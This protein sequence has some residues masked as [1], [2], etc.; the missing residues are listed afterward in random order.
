MNKKI[1]IVIVAALLFV[2][3]NA[4]AWGA[5]GHGAI[6][7]IAEKH[8]TPKAKAECRCYLSH[9]LPYYSSWMDRWRGV[10]P[11]HP[12]NDWHGFPVGANGD[13]DWD[14]ANGKAMGQLHRIVNEM[15]NGNYKK[16][17]DSL[18]RQNL[19][20][21][22]HMLPD[23]HCPVHVTFS[24]K[25]YPEY[26]Y[27]IKRNGRPYKTHTFWD[28]STTFTRKGWTYEKY[29]SEVDK[30]TPKQVKK[31][32]KK[33]NLTYWGQDII[34]QAHRAY[35]LTPKGVDVAE[36]TDEEKAQALALADEMALKAAYRL[37][38]LLNDIFK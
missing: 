32:V 22:V 19:L 18:V 1:F 20:I 12:T 33:G 7:Y 24:K 8:L 9:T 25:Y 26:R 21:L 23:M 5:F 13:V 36:F 35:V 34:K 16:L 30:V 28:A 29:A 38:Y 3:N 6:A 37:A 11:F 27:S 14:N 17:S 10:P 31:I 15:G 2:S 4:M